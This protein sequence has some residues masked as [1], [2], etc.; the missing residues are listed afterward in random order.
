MTK[1]AEECGALHNTSDVIYDVDLQDGS[2]VFNQ[3]E[4][5]AFEQAVLAKRDEEVKR[6]EQGFTTIG[7]LLTDANSEIESLQAKLAMQADLIKRM[8]KLIADSC[9]GNPPPE[10]VTVSLVCAHI[11]VLRCE[12]DHFKETGELLFAQPTQAD[13]DN[14]L[15]GKKAE[16][17]KGRNPKCATHGYGCGLHEATCKVEV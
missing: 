5:L 14:W 9:F 17:E 8:P 13:V 1:L 3:K 4:L 15:Q 16:W 7:K 10:N 11:C 2:F 12:H 6:L